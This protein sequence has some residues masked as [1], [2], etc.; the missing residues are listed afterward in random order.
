MCMY[1]I[2]G[3]DAREYGPIPVDQVRQWIREGRANAQTKVQVE[4]RGDWT[5]LGELAE[6]ED[7][8]GRKPE[9]VP[10]VGAHSPLPADVLERDY[11][12]DIGACISRGA[13]L[14]KANFGLVFGACAIYLL[15]Q[16]AINGL[17]AIPFIG[18][19]FSIGSLF[20][21]G[22]L[23]AGAYLVILKVQRQQ[24]TEIGEVFIGFRTAYVQLLLT[25]LVVTLLTMAAALPG[26]A[27]TA[28]PVI[29][30][31]NN[32]AVN[33]GLVILAILGVIVVLVPTIY[34]TVIWMFSLPLVIDKGLGFW[35]A[36]ETSRKVVSKH[37]W[38]VFAFAIVIGLINL[39]GVMLCCVGL[40]LSFPLAIAAAMV[41]YETLFSPREGNTA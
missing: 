8:L 27:L 29:I 6:F 18:P 5:T 34:L 21:M 17:G 41:A 3:A 10:P 20:V 32:E 38:T 33:A 7:L 13:G 39:V 26:A 36:M 24:P 25:Y 9:S 23:M 16:G 40:F 31:A 37:W 28:V 30:M 1:K 2:I 11:D 4:G 35:Q 22:Q 12:L 19:L 14:L 15:I